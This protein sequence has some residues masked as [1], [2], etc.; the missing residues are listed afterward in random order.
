M[1]TPTATLRC[2][3]CGQPTP[4]DRYP[5]LY[6][7][8]RSALG[9]VEPTPEEDRILHWLAGLDE[10]TVAPLASLFERLRAGCQ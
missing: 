8:L 7:R 2:P 4:H 1:P 6:D 9:D 3:K 10:R 5:C